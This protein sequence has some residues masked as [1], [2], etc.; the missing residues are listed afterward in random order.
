MKAFAN[1]AQHVVLLMKDRSMG[2][3]KIPLLAVSPYPL[4]S[5]YKDMNGQSMSNN[6]AIERKDLDPA[7]FDLKSEGIDSLDW[8]IK[9]EHAFVSMC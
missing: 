4:C 1:P 5:S 2:Y 7:K 9:S 6:V 3:H 8:I